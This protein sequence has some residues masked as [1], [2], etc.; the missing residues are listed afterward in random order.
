MKLNGILYYKRRKEITD[1]RLNH[2][3][4][5]EMK[6]Y[7]IYVMNNTKNAF[8]EYQIFYILLTPTPWLTIAQITMGSIDQSAKLLINVFN[9]MNMSIVAERIL[10]FAL[11]NSRI[12][13]NQFQ[14]VFHIP[15]IDR[16]LFQLFLW[17]I[18]V[19]A[20]QKIPLQSKPIAIL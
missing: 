3:H 13:F 4:I 20:F 18:C 15:S 9:I 11:I 12:Q 17:C 5:I 6:I 14:F 19:C 2:N 8:N 1:H 10:V 16:F 7:Y